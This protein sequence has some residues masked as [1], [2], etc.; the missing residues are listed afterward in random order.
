MLSRLRERKKKSQEPR[1]RLIGRYYLLASLLVVVDYIYYIEYLR[2][3][4]KLLPSLAFW[5]HSSR[6]LVSFPLERQ[7]HNQDRFQ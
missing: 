3:I 7:F 1:V 2:L 5:F 4:A 6:I